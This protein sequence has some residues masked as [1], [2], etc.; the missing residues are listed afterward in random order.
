LWLKS[1]GVLL[2]LDVVVDRLQGFSQL[3]GEL[4]EDLAE[5]LLGV[6]LAE[7]PVGLGEVLDHG[8]EALVDSSVQSGDGILRNFTEKDSIVVVGIDVDWLVINDVGA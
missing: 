8:F 5:L 6:L 1:L 2:Q 4:V 3:V 7:F